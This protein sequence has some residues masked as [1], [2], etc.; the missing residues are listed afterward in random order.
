M[1]YLTYVASNRNPAA[2]ESHR[3]MNLALREEHRAE[4]PVRERL[5]AEGCC[6][7]VPNRLLRP[8]FPEPLPGPPYGQVMARDVSA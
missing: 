4:L 5:P 3:A 7:C 2:E 8:D 1:Y 6:C